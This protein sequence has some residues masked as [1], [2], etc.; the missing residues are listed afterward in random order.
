MKTIAQKIEEAL[1]DINMTQK[2]LAKKTGVTE[3]T[4]SRYLSG[5]RN[6]RGEILSK[7][8]DVLGLTTDYLLGNSEVKHPSNAGSLTPKDEKDIEKA[9][10][11][12]LEIL[13]SQKGLM[14]SGNPVDEEDFE[15]IKLAI[16]NGLEYAKISNK[17][18]YTPKKYRK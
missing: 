3:A 12:T 4:I 17:K 9:L 1:S 11:K 6:P 5:A 8:A 2:E 18:K 16:H 7:I 10:N 15:L 14:L 13:Q